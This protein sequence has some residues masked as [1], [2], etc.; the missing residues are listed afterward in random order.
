MTNDAVRLRTGIAACVGEAMQ[1]KQRQRY[2][3][4]SHGHRPKFY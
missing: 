3:V 1:S 2:R 4:S